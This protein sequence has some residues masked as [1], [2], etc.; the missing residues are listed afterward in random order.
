MTP[1]LINQFNEYGI[2]SEHF[3]HEFEEFLIL[4]KITGAVYMS[5]LANLIASE[6]SLPLI[7]DDINFQIIAR[8]AQ[9]DRIITDDLGESLASMVIQSVIPKNIND[10]SVDKITKFRKEFKDERQEFYV[11]INE[12][13]KDL[14][15]IEDEQSLKDALHF[16]HEE[17]IRSTKRIKSILHGLKIDTTLGVMSLSVPSFASNLGWAVAGTGVIA[18]AMGKLALKGIEYK[19]SR[20]N[21]PYSYALSLQN[22]L[23]TEDLAESI[24]KGKIVL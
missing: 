8:E 2:H 18:I 12:L 6:K 16:K 3:M 15:K 14:Y 22:K 23:T 19:K 9:K 1:E 7:S 24:L 10:I 20:N 11:R 4:D 21:T 13:V 17:I 5:R